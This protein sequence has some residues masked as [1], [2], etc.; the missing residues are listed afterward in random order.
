MTNLLVTGSI[1][2]DRIS[3][4]PDRFGNHILPDKVHRLN[5]A[6]NVKEMTINYGGTGGNIAYNLGLLGEKPLLLGTI[7]D[8]IEDY[9]EF[10]KS[11]NVNCTYVKE[12]PMKLTAH[13]TIMTDMDDNQIT[14]FYMG[15][16][17]YAQRAKM[18][19]IKE[20]IEL[21]I[22]APNGINAM[23][24]YADHCSE[25]K[26]PYIF[27]PGQSIPALSKK[28]LTDLLKR[29]YILVVNDYEWELIRQ[30][31]GFDLP[32]VLKNTKYLIITY[33]EKGSQI[34]HQDATVTEVSA[35]KAKKVVDPTGC[36]DAYLAGLM[37]GLK[38]NYSIE[39]AAYIGAWVAVQ[40]IEK[41][42]TQNHTI[43]KI[44]FNK[45]L[46]KLKK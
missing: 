27:S 5:V 30:K 34:W 21:A 6:F 10:L 29:A 23:S 40:A 31:T 16:M 45:F 36:G 38:N 18:S 46:S 15:A 26:I 39:N 11:H 35:V 41:R 44:D 33:G 2:L 25:N 13:A 43:S 20:E 8:D 4:F 19:D 32:S 28:D 17:E 24:D 9:I 42:G 22:I 14:A 3:V 1:A 12:I 37:Y 7:G